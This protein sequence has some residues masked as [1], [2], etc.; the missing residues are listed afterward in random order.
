MKLFRS[1]KQQAQGIL[2]SYK[3]KGPATYAAAQQAIGAVLIADGLVGIENPFGQKKRPGIFGTIGG[4][5]VGI[6]FILFSSFFGSI[7][8][9]D[10]MT[11]S[12]QATV[13]SVGSMTQSSQSS[14]GSCSLTASY[15][16]D[17]QSYTQSSPIS[18]SSNCGLVAGQTIMINYDPTSPGTWAYGA[19]TIGKFMKVFPIVGVVIL[20]S[21]IVQFIIR[22]LSIIFGWKLLKNGRKN[23]AGLPPETN[24]KTMIDEI[25]KN[26]TA[27]VFG[28]GG[29]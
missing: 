4:M 14:S 26:F 6:V 22:L 11:A 17:G 25:K 23:A 13:V 5:V 27:S 29:N 2:D 24:L 28:F 16:V 12:T 9:V 3:S 7:M 8:G 19:E 1:L 20:L 18:S 21:S 15:F 10:K